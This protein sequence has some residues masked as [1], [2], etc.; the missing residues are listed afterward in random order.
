MDQLPLPGPCTYRWYGPRADVPGADANHVCE[1]VG[2][3]DQDHRCRCGATLSLEAWLAHV[4]PDE[5]YG[6]D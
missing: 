5:A 4:H 2:D 3:H 1:V 6:D